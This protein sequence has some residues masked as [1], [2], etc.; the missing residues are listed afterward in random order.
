[1]E[2]KSRKKVELA[3]VR[4]LLTNKAY[5]CSILGYAAVTFS[6]G[7]IS[8]WMPS[9]LNRVDGRSMEAAG[10]IMGG[11]TVVC[12]LGGTVVGGLLA[13]WWS[14]KTSKA[15]YLVPALSAVLAVP[16][17]VLCFFG[18]KTILL[19]ALGVAVFLVFLGTGP[20]NAATLNAVPA[21]LRAMAMAGQLF[22]LHVFGDA[23]SPKIIGIVSDHTNLRMGLGVTLIAF[24]AG[25]RD[26]LYRIKV[27]A[28]IDA[29]AG[30]RGG[31]N[32]HGLHFHVTEFWRGIIR[33]VWWALTLVWVLRT[34]DAVRYMPHAAGPYAAGLDALPEGL[35]TLTVVVPARDEAEKIAA[36]IDAL[37]MADYVGVRVLVVDDRSTD[38]TGAIVDACVEQYARRRP[39]A[40]SAIHITELPE[41]WLG[42]TFALMVATENSSSDYL[43]FTDADVLFSPSI[44][45]RAL[46]CAQ[47]LAADHL[48][49]MPTVEVRARGEGI[50]LGFMQI[51]SLWA[52]R[53]WKVE[54]PRRGGML[55]G[56]GHSIWCGATRSMRLVDGFHSVWRC[57]RTLHWGDGCGPQRCGSGSRLRRVWCWCTG[58]RAAT[59]CCST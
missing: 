13:H 57:L 31:L 25:G 44:L 27:C 51:M 47:E 8:W 16:P 10:T 50:V 59:D 17:A 49:V 6:L 28:A 11:I 34:Y 20:V 18:P 15:L 36:T 9:F 32:W 7:G 30:G 14:K 46:V 52:V 53:P 23:F 4:S 38:G 12:G 56:S 22:V 55:P 43:L 54:I 42:K 58:P 29:F 35:P 41:G 48:V 3:S 45:R 2:T 21:H 24:A 19:P 1:M 39:G 37:M 26:L 5:L 40:L 33:T